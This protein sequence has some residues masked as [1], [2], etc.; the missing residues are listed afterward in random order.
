MN[1]QVP[2]RR[3]A[4]V[5]RDRMPMRPLR[6]RRAAFDR[7]RC[8]PASTRIDLDNKPFDRPARSAPI[9]PQPPGEQSTRR[10]AARERPAAQPGRAMPEL[11]DHRFDRDRAAPRRAPARRPALAAAAGCQAQRTAQWRSRRCAGCRSGASGRAMEDGARRIDAHGTP[12]GA[13]CPHRHAN[14]PACDSPLPGAASGL[15]ADGMR[16]RRVASLL[17]TLTSASTSSH[18]L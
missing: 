15:L 13:P 12:S 10:T 1:I 2:G 3:R 5:S 6:S 4:H 18:V 11:R 9:M 17:T 7:A 14:E 8:V 16:Q